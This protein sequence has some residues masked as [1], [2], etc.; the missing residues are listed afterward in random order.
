MENEMKWN[1]RNKTSNKNISSSYNNNN[2][3][4]FKIGFVLNTQMTSDASTLIK[5]TWA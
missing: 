2:R 4:N 5:S 3:S 1:R